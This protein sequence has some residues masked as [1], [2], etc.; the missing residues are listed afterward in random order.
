MDRINT[1]V[2]LFGVIAMTEPTVEPITDPVLLAFEEAKSNVVPPLVP[3]PEQPN[4]H[5]PPVEAVSGSGGI[6]GVQPA[7][8]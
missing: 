6:P 8:E 1:V 4:V 3:N 2:K 5:I 7:E